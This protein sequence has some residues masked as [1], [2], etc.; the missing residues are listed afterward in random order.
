MAQ[1]K[2]SGN[3]ELTK[4][5]E[6]LKESNAAFYVT[7]VNVGSNNRYIVVSLCNVFVMESP[8]ILSDSIVELVDAAK[9]ELNREVAVML[10][11]ADAKKAIVAANVRFLI[12][13]IC[14]FS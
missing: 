14:L 12:D 8:S 10:F 9:R 7:S 4:A 3:E 13:S 5:V 1:D 11:S 6:A 2:A